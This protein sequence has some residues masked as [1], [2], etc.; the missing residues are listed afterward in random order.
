MR[1]RLGL[2]GSDANIDEATRAAVNY[3][4]GGPNGVIGTTP[5]ENLKGITELLSVTP[6]LS[7][8]IKLYPDVM[9]ASKDLEE[10]SGG[11]VRAGDEMKVL[12][13]ALEN[14]GGGIDPKTHELSPERMK[15]AVNEAVKT[16]IAGGG[17]IDGAT[18]FGLAKQSGGMG[19]MTDPGNLFDETITSLIDMGGQRT[20]T[21]LSALGRQ[22]LGDKMTKQ[23]A[24]ELEDLGILPH[25][26]W[27]TGGGSGIIMNPGYDIKGIDDIKSGNLPDFMLNVLGPAIRA[28][29]GDSNPELME[30]S[31]KIFGQQTGQRLGL[32]FLQNEAQRQRDVALRHGVD[33]DSV[34]KGIAEKDYQANLTNLGTSAQGLTQVVGAG[35]VP[36]AN[37]GLQALSSVFNW[38]AKL[39][40]DHPTITSDVLGAVNTPMLIANTLAALDPTKHLTAPPVPGVGDHISDDLAARRAL[41]EKLNPSG[42]AKPYD[43]LSSVHAPASI[44]SPPVT[45]NAPITAPVSGDLHATITNNI[46]VTGMVQTIVSEVTAKMQGALSGMINAIKGSAMNSAASFDGRSDPTPADSTA[47]PF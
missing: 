23:T 6:G 12:A 11:K 26:S 47:L 10:L 35:A 15:T 36:N 1:D 22:F 4:T 39:G 18:L 46:N 2:K 38:L 33:P 45:I 9:K 40:A 25:G 42:L 20:G 34:Y 27:R 24:S 44:A 8:A 7:D 43:P 32:M 29:V 41:F 28:K 3:A 5:A 19:R 37:I 31:Y 14:L 30:E 13:K 16:I 17:F 21:A